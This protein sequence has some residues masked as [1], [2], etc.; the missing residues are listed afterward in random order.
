MFNKPKQSPAQAASQ[1]ENQEITSEKLKQAL[2]DCPDIIFSDIAVNTLKKLRLTVVFVDGMVNQQMIDDYIL[3]PLVQEDV[4]R[5]AKSHQ[6]VIDL[7]IHGTVY[8]NQRRLRDTLDDCINDLLTGSIALIFDETKEAVTFELKGFEKRSI[9]EPTNEN[10]L[11]GSKEAFVEV[12]RVNTA[13]VRRRLPTKD[14]KFLR[15]EL[16]SRSKTL[17]NIVYLNGVTNMN[18]VS[19]VKRRLENSKYDGIVSAGQI[20]GFLLDNAASFFPQVLYTERTD[21]FCANIMEGR[22]GIMIDGMPLVY[23]VPVDINS[24]LQAPEDY[25]L[26]YLT[27][28]MFRFLRHV[29]AFAALIL[30]AIYVGMTTFHQDMLPSEL[31]ISIVTSKQGV[32]FPTFIEVLIMLFA[33]EVLL[34]AG[35]RLP[36]AIGQAVSIVGAVVV[37]QAAITAKLLSPGVVIIIAAAGIT[38]FVV[39]SQ[40]LSNTIRICRIFLVICAIIGGL[41]GV[42]VGLIVILYHMCTLE[43]FD[44]PY[45]SPFVANEGAEMFNDTVVRRSWFKL[46]RRPKN[47]GAGDNIRQGS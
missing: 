14:L 35:L 12:L 20:E 31:I 25:A 34:E 42:I 27:S 4:F 18:T 3:K 44:T 38:G 15:L 8:H 21:K 29:S 39:P 13:L 45:M 26:S 30:P 36:R 19:E 5:D 22:V 16:G 17:V 2:C 6:A 23:I 32:P 10:V 7:I 41:F 1:P 24:F 28:S 9:T 43:V 40:D 46:K 33:F 47:V 37:G 11:K